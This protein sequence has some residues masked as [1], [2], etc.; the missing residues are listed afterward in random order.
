MSECARDFSQQPGEGVLLVGNNHLLP[1]GVVSDLTV[2]PQWSAMRPSLFCPHLDA[3]VLRTVR[4][5]HG[6]TLVRLDT[7]ILCKI[8]HG[9]QFVE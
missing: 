4:L 6:R 8:V 7:V 9:E 3:F 2:K 5:R 1:G